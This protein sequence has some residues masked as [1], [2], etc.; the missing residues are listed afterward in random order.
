MDG[1][2]AL[3]VIAIHRPRTEKFES[4]SRNMLSKATVPRHQQYV[5]HYVTEYYNSMIL[6][7]NGVTE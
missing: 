5:D 4:F 1:M 7:M 2:R 6:I 3:Q